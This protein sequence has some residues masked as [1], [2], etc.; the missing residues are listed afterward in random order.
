MRGGELVAEDSW[1]VIPPTGADN[2]DP[3]NVM[4]HHITPDFV[5]KRGLTWEDSLERFEA[6]A[7]VGE[8]LIAHNAPFDRGVFERSTKHVGL[9]VP[10]HRWED[11]VTLARRNL[12]LHNHKLP[13]VAHHLGIRFENH[14]DACADA[15]ACAL[16]ATGIAMQIGARS[17]D[18]LWPGGGGAN[19]WGSMSGRGRRKRELAAYGHTASGPDSADEIDRAQRPGGPPRD[20][21]GYGSGY[22]SGRANWEGTGRPSRGT[23]SGETG[24][25]AWRGSIRKADIPSPD[26]GADPTHPLYGQTV[27]ITGDLP[28]MDRMG[29]FKALAAKGAQPQNNVTLA[30]TML[31]VASRYDLPEDYDPGVGT[32]KERKAAEY[33]DRRGRPVRFIGA[34]KALELL[35]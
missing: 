18:D 30:T 5:K 29:V 4:I 9:A 11:T 32:S 14:H 31:I 35:S 24:H 7:G 10:S 1:Y 33:R 3:F 19:A 13:T 21:A 15:V 12:G 34:Q 16:I 6:F 26:T 23:G 25:P 2:F 22:R 17:V 20:G 27:A 28:G 8:V